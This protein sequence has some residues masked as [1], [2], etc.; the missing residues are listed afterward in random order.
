MKPIP[1]SGQP[2]TRVGLPT[3]NGALIDTTWY[4]F[5]KQ[6]LAQFSAYAGLLDG[7]VPVASLPAA[8]IP[9]RLAVVTD[10]NATTWGSTVSGGGANTVLAWDNGSNWTIIGK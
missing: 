7:G 2:I 10:A 6:F 9:G 1:S 8:G 3:R 5:L 4:D